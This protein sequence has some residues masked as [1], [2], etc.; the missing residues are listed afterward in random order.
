MISRPRSFLYL[1][2]FL[3][4]APGALR[5]QAQE[6]LTARLASVDTRI[7]VAAGEHAPRLTALTGAAGAAWHNRAEET[8]PDL[9]NDDGTRQALRWR[10]DR[11]A[12]HSDSRNIE[13]VYV[14]EAPTL[15][16]RWVWRVRAP[17][18][19]I[20]HLVFVENL[21]GRTLL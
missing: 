16:L 18:G 4:P 10:L 17:H 15:R 2:A 19:P 7:D 5:A 6:A 8:L 11:N 9:L 21:S 12:S 14:S 1:I 20:E 13:L 3:L